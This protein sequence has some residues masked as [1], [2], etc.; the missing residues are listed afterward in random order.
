MIGKI[1]VPKRKINCSVCDTFFAPETL[2]TSRLFLGERGVI[3]RFDTCTVCE[4]PSGKKEISCWKT[5][6]PSKKT[7]GIKQKQGKAKELFD[8]L[9]KEA[10]DS[11]S[12][13]YV[14]ALYLERRRTLIRRDVLREGDREIIL[15]ES[16]RSGEL[17]PIVHTTLTASA[18][19][20]IGEELGNILS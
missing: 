10:E 6:F 9:F 3:E 18:L 8:K 17:Y 19:E 15:F 13:L 2:M 16:V 11:F 20:E 4:C 1:E 7:L 12:Q 5:V 14:L